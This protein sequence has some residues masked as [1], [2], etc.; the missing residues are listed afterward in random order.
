MWLITTFPSCNYNIE[1][2]PAVKKHLLSYGIHRLEQSGKKYIIEG[3][4]IKSRKKT[5]NKWF[6]TQDSINYWDDFNKQ[7]IIYPETTQGAYFVLDNNNYYIDKTCFM[8]TGEHLKY[9]LGTLSSALFEYAYKNIFTSI[10]LGKSGYQ[11]NKYSLLKLPIY[12]PTKNE[13]QTV[14]EIIDKIVLSKSSDYTKKLDDYIF[15]IYGITE[16]EKEERN[17]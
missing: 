3:K 4:E 8:M 2:Y 14:E 1:N 16:K 15:S 6:E 13:E 10:E 5:N 12:Y 17:I 11:Y 7:K 9:L